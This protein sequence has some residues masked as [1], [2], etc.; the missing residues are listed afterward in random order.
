MKKIIY[1]FSGYFGTPLSK[2]I[3]II[4]VI[5]ALSSHIA[6]MAQDKNIAF[7]DIKQIADH[8]AAEFWGDVHPDSPTPYYG[9]NDEIIAYQ[10]NYAIGKEFP[11]KETLLDKCNKAFE[12]GNRDAGWGND[13]YANMVFGANRAMPVF[14][15]GSKCLSKQYAYGVR[16]EQTAIKELGSGYSFDKTYYLGMA[17]VWFCYVNGSN[18]KFINPEPY[19]KILDET[20]F[21]KYIQDIDYFWQRDSFDKDWPKF[22]KNKEPVKSGIVFIPG[23]EAPFMPYLEWSYGCTPTAAAMLLAWWD[24]LQDYG[25]LIKYYMDRWDPVQNNTDY[26]V[27]DAQ[28]ALASWMETDPDGTTYRWNI[29]DG[30]EWYVESR[31]Y[32]CSSDSHW[33]F[34]WSVETLFD[35]IKS[36]IDNQKPLLVGIYKHSLTGV[37]YNNSNKT[38]YV[39]DPNHSSLHYV[40]RSQLKATY[41]FSIS[42]NYGT[43]VRLVSPHGGNIWNGNGGDNETL[44]SNDFF[45]IEWRSPH[46]TNTFARLYYSDEGGTQN[47]HWFPITNGTENDGQY[48][49]HI[50]EINCSYGDTTD[51]A[52]VKVEIYNM[53]N[54]LIAS[55]G[56]YGN[57][58][59]NPGGGLAP[60]HYIVSTQTDPDFF[61]INMSDPH[62][63][64]ISIQDSYQSSFWY[65]HLFNNIGF[66]NIIEQ[67]NSW[68]MVNYIVINGQEIP[69]HEYGIK[70]Y[71]Q[72]SS[73][74]SAILSFD[75]DPYEI[76]VDAVFSKSWPSDYSSLIWNVHLIPGYYYFK[77]DIDST[78]LLDLDMALFERGGDNIFARNDNVAFSSNTGTGIDESFHYQIDFE[79]DYGL[80]INSNNSETDT[81]NV[82]VIVPGK[83]SGDVSTNWHNPANW[84]S[85][86][87]PT[88]NNSVVIPSGC[89]HYPSVYDETAYSM[90]VTV[91]AGASLTINNKYMNVYGDLHIFGELKMLGMGSTLTVESSI[92]WESGSTANILTDYAVINCYRNWIFHN[93]S[94]AQIQKGTVR[95][96]NSLDSYILCYSSNSGFNDIII[97]KP[98]G[99]LQFGALSNK[100]LHIAGNLTIN[101]S[102]TFKS[103]CGS[104]IL[105][106]GSFTN[107]GHFMFDN[108][109]FSLINNSINIDCNT[110]DYFN[111]LRITSI[112]PCVLSNDLHLQGDLM[113]VSGGLVTLS[114]D[115]YIGGNWQNIIGPDYFV[116]GSGTVLFNDQQD[117]YC[118]G[119]E[120]HNLELVSGG[121]YF[122][123]GTTVCYR[124]K[125][126]DGYLNI[127]GGTFTANDLYTGEGITGEIT[128]SDGEINFHQ[129]MQS[130]IGLN[131]DL[132][133]TGGTLN[134][135][136]GGGENSYWASARSIDI[137]MEAGTIDFKDMGIRIWDYPAHNINTEITGGTIRTS[138]DL[139]CDRNGFNPEGG[140][141]EL[142]GPNP[143]SVNCVSQSNF[144]DLVINKDA[145]KSNTKPKTVLSTPQLKAPGSTQTTLNNNLNINNNLSVSSGS[146]N[147]NGYKLEVGNDMTIMDNLIMNDPADELIVQKDINWEENSTTD[148]TEGLIKFGEYFNIGQNSSVQLGVNTELDVIGENPSFIVN[149][150]T[151]TTF[152][153]ICFF[154]TASQTQFTSPSNPFIVN[155]AIVIDSNNTVRLE[156][157]DLTVDGT[158]FIEGNSYLFNTTG[159]IEANSLTILKGEL[160]V[161]SGNITCHSGFDTYSGSN[162][163]IQGG[164]LVLDRPYSATYFFLAGDVQIDGGT[165]EIASEG[166]RMGPSASLIMNNGIVKVGWGILAEYQNNFI[167][168]G[169]KVIMTGNSNGAIMFEN[170]NNLYNLRIDKT[171]SAIITL[172]NDLTLNNRLSVN[173]GHLNILS[174]NLYVLDD[175]LIYPSG[176]LEVSDGSIEVS[177]DW[178]NSG[179]YPNFDEGTSTVIFTGNEESHILNNETF[180]DLEINKTGDDYTYVHVDYGL[181]VNINNNLYITNRSL[182]V[183]D[184]AILNVN[185][186][187]VIS[188]DACLLAA[189]NQTSNINIGGN[190]NNHNTS[191]NPITYGFFPGLSTVTFNGNEDQYVD[192]DYS[193]QQFYDLVID[194]PQNAFYPLTDIS[195]SNDLSINNGEWGDDDPGH[196]YN[197]YGDITI[198][199]NGDFNDNSCTVNILGNEDMDLNNFSSNVPVFNNLIINMGDQFQI[200][201]LESDIFCENNF[202]VNNG[203]VSVHSARIECLNNFTVN[204][205]SFAFIDHASTVAMGPGGQLLVDGGMLEILKYT[206]T[207]F[208]KITHT[209]GYYGFQVTNNGILDAVGVTFEFMD[210]HGV[211]ITET[212]L[213]YGTNTFNNCTFQNGASGG[214]L[215][216]I[217]NDEDLVINGANF[218]DNTWAGNYNVTKTSDQGIISFSNVTGDFAGPAFENDPYSRIDWGAMIPGIWTGTVSDVWNNPAN[219]QNSLMPGP[220]DD[221]YIPAGTPNDPVISV[222]DQECN[223]I[224]IESG[225]MFE[226]YNK[227]LTVHGDMVIY[228]ELRMKQANSILYAGDGFGDVI[229]WEA[230]S[231][232]DI[233]LGTIYVAGDWN[234]KIGTTA[235]LGFGNTVIFNGDDF[236]TIYCNDDDATFGTL[237]INKPSPPK[238]YVFVSDRNSLR[239]SEDLYILDGS[240][241]VKEGCDVFVGNEFDVFNGGTFNILGTSALPSSFSGDIDYCLFEVTSGGAISA[242]Y[243]VFEN[244]GS[245]GILINSGAYVN[246]NYPFSHCTFR[247]SPVG[248]TLLTISNNQ[249][250]TIDGAVFPLNTWSGNYNVSKTNDEGH[251]T[252]TNVD[253]GFVGETFENDPNNRVD[254][255]GVT[256]GIWEGTVS[257]IWNDSANWKY[258]LKPSAYDDVT[259]SSSAPHQP[260]IMDANQEC[261]NLSV[262]T[263]ASLIFRNRTLSVHGDLT[264]YGTI[265]MT[266]PDDTLNAGDD[267]GDNVA[268]RAG[269]TA[270]ISDGSINVFG[271]WYFY[272][273]IDV[274]FGKNNTTTFYGNNTSS[275]YCYEDNA[276]FGS[277]TINKTSPPHDVV[278]LNSDHSVKVN[279]A[280][281]ISDGVFRLSGT[282]VFTVNNSIYIDDGATINSFGTIADPASILGGTGYCDFKV[283]AGGTIGASYTI[284]EN[285]ETDGVMVDYD[286]IIDTLHPFNNCTFMNGR[287]GG[288]LLTINNE[289]FITIDSVSF[290]EN[291]WNGSYNVT[292]NQNG[293]QVTLTN[294]NGIFAGD[295][296]EYD[297]YSRIDWT[298]PTFWLHVKV[299]LEGPFNG[300]NMN[301]GMND[302]PL[303]QP[304]NTSPWNYDGYESVPQIPNHVVDWVLVELRSAPDSASATSDR[305]LERR[306]AFLK[307]DGTITD[308]SGLL[309]MQFDKYISQ[310]LYVV[311][312]HRNHL[313]VM[314]A[315]PLQKV[316]KTFSYDFTPEKNQ[317]YGSNNGHKQ[318]VPGVWGMIGGDG[319]PDGNITDYDHQNVWR[320]TT[321]QKGY[322]NA[323]YNLDGQVENK[324]KNDV[325]VGNYL[326]SSQVPE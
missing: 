91:E 232:C 252:F 195:V 102:S 312:R 50:P 197:F 188:D 13:D 123:S 304:F 310:Q 189:S 164:E 306:A 285:M 94:T 228:G 146:L 121:L 173:S 150:A 308:L 166:I 298:V 54:E 253:G 111:N 296:F 93:G 194:K 75:N 32:N 89:S 154:K 128:M 169:G 270:L 57:F 31:G 317:A 28:K 205:G 305:I 216:Q 86:S 220:S 156:G 66:Q 55:D 303:A 3:K 292:K 185:G 127:S 67:S 165:F 291:T 84:T 223:N 204:S 130:M 52:R 46:D 145:T 124:Y 299:Y 231:G 151:A 175:I 268:W 12:S 72:Y 131:A 229:S 80:C 108:G 254:W 277:L 39:H 163:N 293:G 44:G 323:D 322:L 286:A 174:N 264:I 182:G 311:V 38:V 295:Y 301:Y 76:P 73:E 315:F 129:D 106:E 109:S 177:G 34:Y 241:D 183:N 237:N 141:F 224:T 152:G 203:E 179:G 77:L 249:S 269:S 289:Q 260:M 24:N 282:S 180:Y 201:N 79:G 213:L 1:T 280:F 281:Y 137:H 279:D 22:L 238:D 278:T 273:G 107:N 214:T 234:F 251:I 236:S 98:G 199:S 23:N 19:T 187:I 36:E 115:I 148:V 134:I 7:K 226:I 283:A 196:T 233:T 170:S 321:G 202:I 27:P 265:S 58:S 70:A 116:E 132:Y 147:L 211:N 88:F 21:L 41:W 51:H 178:D 15:E 133:I 272:D 140:T 225:V 239:V 87:V 48:I 172:V 81:F 247:K 267:P 246:I 209:S 245:S 47:D 136:G 324:D 313:D 9:P 96:V 10:F 97:D 105:L 262:H 320:P 99:V 17:E 210:T 271:S 4:T 259:I 200:F 217:N 82:S 83:W 95:F 74:E 326:Q 69:P 65:L 287:E 18:K 30:V 68:D 45:E 42:N 144:Y 26:H 37:G 235:Q 266:H 192:A 40:S 59:I 261:E 263:G 167:A 207:D 71:A 125:Y 168:N 62:W 248:G 161:N 159:N 257:N 244:I 314:S 149:D 184:F 122:P 243:T 155:G 14:I 162:L 219:W 319:K 227:T 171:S 142:Y 230:G 297:P 61:S 139:I 35:D 309:D 100:D 218:P 85:N 158:L 258:Y 318:L 103:E 2:G 43:S 206:G 221:V 191:G 16:L 160:N 53:Q 90:D 276:A 143:T 118:Y 110:G 208:P 193:Q 60:I 114:N 6:L 153:K 250:L 256:A 119:E 255:P 290:P 176:H 325:W 288:T 11:D 113:I 316:Y 64:V 56:S 307:D 20:A 275:I 138:G 215:L 92:T 63:S 240:L 8:Y 300:I 135:Y 33:A 198:Q 126:T 222:T 302:M 78:S 29:C 284:F 112:A 117:S 212:G 274:S 5:L 181:T 49:W 294:F 104:S 242:D 157:V 101:P 186:D 190:W 25:N 120:F